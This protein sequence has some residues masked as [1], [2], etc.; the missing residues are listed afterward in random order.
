MPAHYIRDPHT[1]CIMNGCQFPAAVQCLAAAQKV[2]DE[3]KKKGSK[4][5][6]ALSLWCEIG[7]HGFSSKKGHVEISRRVFD[8]NGDDIDDESTYV[9]S[10]RD[11]DPYSKS[12]D[13]DIHDAITA[14]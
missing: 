6:A 13:G 11:H 14:S 4:M 2:L 8:G 9:T 12:E 7:D 5:P 10:C 1:A 3:S